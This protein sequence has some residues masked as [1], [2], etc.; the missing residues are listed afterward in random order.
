M[1]KRDVSLSFQ[2]H[3]AGFTHTLDLD[4][5]H[6]DFKRTDQCHEL[7]V[8]RQLVTA[9]VGSQYSGTGLREEDPGGQPEM[10]ASLHLCFP[11][12]DTLEP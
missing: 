2:G 8:L 6:P 10:V 12:K 5:Q 3:T 7:H 4:L 9:A 11:Q 1:G